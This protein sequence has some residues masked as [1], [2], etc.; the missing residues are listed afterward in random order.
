MDRNMEEKTAGVGISATG[1][2]D[3]LRQEVIKKLEKFSNRNIKIW[4]ENGKLKFRAATGLMTDEDKRYLKVNKQAVIAC[5]LDD[6]VNLE[7]DET[8]QFDPFPLT[9]IQQAYVLGRNPA[10]PYGGT[11]CHIYL[12]FEYD[13]LDPNRVEEVW[14]HL[15]SRHPMLRA[16][17][18]AD[19]YQ[20]VMEKAPNFQVICRDYKD[21]EAAARG[22]DAIKAEYDHKIYDTNQ[23]PLFTVAV[24]R[25]PENAVL[26]LSIE[27]VTADWTSI[28]TVLSEFESLYFDPAEALPDL[29]V[30]FRD[31]VLAARKLRG[32][33][34]FY[35]DREYWMKRIDRL[36]GAP[37]F[38][39][40]LGID[41]NDV[42]FRRDQFF[43]K[44]ADWDQFCEYAR[45]AG[46]TPAAAV[47]AAY[48]ATLARWSRNKDFC[49]NLSILNRLDL[50]PE[51]GS[52]VGDFTESSL[53]EVNRCKGQSF[54]EFVS[55]INRRLFD[56]LDHRSFTG[57]DVLRALQQREDRE[58]LMP[59]VFTGA[60]GLIDPRKSALRGRM[61]DRGISQTAQ[62]FM[63]CQAMDTRDGLNI[64]LDSRVGVFP[65][66]LP[67]DIASSMETL[68]Q[69]LSR[70][71]EAWTD[72]TFQLPLPDWQRT[73]IEESN[74]TAYPGQACL[75]HAD[76]LQRIVEKPNR[77]VVADEEQEWS[78]GELY[79]ASQAICAE[80]IEAG[81]KKGDRVTILLPKSRW[82]LAA[83]LSILSV[84]GIYVPADSEQG[85]HR[86]ASI[87]SS[88]GSVLAISNLAN[89]GKLPA[90]FPT[91]VLED[92]RSETGD[93]KEGPD[94]G[95]LSASLSPQDTAY[96]IY[97]SGSTGEPK[98]VEMTHAAAVNT[99]E[100]VNRLFDVTEEDRVLQISQ[101]NFDLS[102]YDLFGVVGAG[103]ALIIPTEADY[104]NPAK[105]V[106]LM[107]RY[108]VTLWNSVPAL[109]QLLLIYK[110][111]NPGVVISDLSKVFLSGD[112]IV[113]TMPAEI[114]N[115]F[116]EA[117]IV[118]MGGA[119]EGGIWSNYH[120]CLEQEDGSFR[121][122][123]PYGKPLPNQGFRILDAFDEESPVWVPGE[124]C[125]TGKSLASSYWGRRD[126]TDKA[127]VLWQGQ[128]LY[129]TGDIGCWHP[130]G[131]ME[132]L[133]RLDNQV[134]I[135][136]HR[137]ELGEIEEIVKKKLDVSECSAVVFGEG[138]E[139]NIAVLITRDPAEESGA[140]IPKSIEEIKGILADWLPTY[141]VPSVYLFDRCLPL[142]ANGKIDKK[143]IRKRAE[144]E[145]SR[146][147][148]R[149]RGEKAL[150]PVEEKILA[151]LRESF[152]FETLGID[153]NFYEA[154]ANSLMLA[155]AAGS[156]NQ[157]IECGASFD[158]WLVQ[159]LNA[160]TA[161]EL[162][163]FAATKNKKSDP[164]AGEEELGEEG[165]DILLENVEGARAL[166]AVF[167][168]GIEDDLIEEVRKGKDLG[169]I[170]I[171]RGTDAEAIVEKILEQTGVGVPVSFLADDQDMNLCLKVA[172]TLVT[173]GLIPDSVNIL[174][175]DSETETERG[176]L[177]VGDVNFGLV[178]STM[179]DADEI[180]DILS[181]S[182]A[183]N[184]EVHDC[185]SRENRRKFLVSILLKGGVVNRGSYNVNVR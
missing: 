175:S 2:S 134:K 92:I 81:V 160:P 165:G 41:N 147:R 150:S 185:R 91:L 21:G 4:T 174:E 125:I 82:Q 148:N 44:K 180:R 25:S 89:R 181:G 14:N 136:G 157:E 128:R 72:K 61:N 126:L 65:E 177:Y 31:Y 22:R 140:V 78:G 143:A 103:G 53:L 57:V 184:L 80:L 161:R 51:I 124:L 133:G 154:G 153:Q 37:E 166:Y 173:R 99:I 100:A 183:G 135:R 96:I 131:E 113:T 42:R 111:Y 117:V 70:S 62:V 79:R 167:V 69:S 123:I 106:Q 59:F 11:A 35:R 179:E 129:R 168:G 52:I 48:A 56:D 151:L 39:V 144:E 95:V 119:T 170:R 32:G 3:R 130:D 1:P 54:A 67:E 94:L 19:G 138:S 114:R 159:L 98:G 47:M 182:C 107:N 9:E 178:H 88:S 12:E 127:F 84:G 90:N 29:H 75:L 105:W 20:Q 7:S 142:T 73:C 45:N 49:L 172:S 132:F 137:I 85:E 158:S 122:S 55:S 6:R 66:G 121:R 46:A 112:W 101:L 152:G 110:Q 86:L 24:T 93:S 5:L 155:R 15:I 163:A 68:L 77:L 164:A 139:Q 18:S 83:C 102:V 58:A 63:D 33:S 71:A 38:P 28:W 27:F 36:P 16:R 26:H 118:S 43:I 176:L 116:P 30:R 13:Q 8:G 171:E 50:H 76:L 23:W 169:L 34:R 97:T 10:F 146:D 120:I 141:M 17:M 40:L 64:N 162:A 149:E 115:V 156:L 104:R 60:I 108:R 74:Q 145:I 87:L 109:L